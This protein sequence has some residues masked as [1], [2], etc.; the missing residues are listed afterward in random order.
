[1]EKWVVRVLNVLNCFRTGSYCAILWDHSESSCSIQQEVTWS[2]ATRCIKECSCR[3][4][5]QWRSFLWKG[6]KIS[7]TTKMV[8]VPFGKTKWKFL[9]PYPYIIL[10]TTASRTA[11]GLTQPPIQWIPGALSLGVKRL[12]READ[13]SPPSSAEVK[14]WT[15]LYLPFF[16]LAPQPSL[17]LGLLHKIRLN[18]LEASQQFSFLQG[19]VVSPTPNPHPGGPGL[20]IIYIPQR[21]GGYPF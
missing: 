19:R 10:F 7:V 20:C 11:L 12:G 5:E 9:S 15:E 8:P 14:E 17:G 2:T 4:T 18:F 21:Q 16:S 6:L 1:L 13:Y 3:A